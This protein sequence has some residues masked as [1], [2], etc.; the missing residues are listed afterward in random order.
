MF[1][2]IYIYSK[3]DLSQ[4]GILFS[5]VTKNLIKGFDH[6]VHGNIIL[7]NSNPKSSSDLDIPIALRKRC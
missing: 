3:E 2:Y 1:P 6:E 7:G 5:I 4:K